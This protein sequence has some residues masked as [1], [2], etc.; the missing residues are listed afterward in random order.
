LDDPGSAVHR[1]A[2]HRVREKRAH[3]LTMPIADI[4]RGTIVACQKFIKLFALS[5]TAPPNRQSAQPAAQKFHD[6]SSRRSPRV[7][8]DIENSRRCGGKIAIGHDT[9]SNRASLRAMSLLRG[10]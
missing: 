8:R 10:V 6:A 9:R 1:Y 4:R 5:T 3:L 7:Q 2:L